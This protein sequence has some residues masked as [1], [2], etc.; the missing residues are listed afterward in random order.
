MLVRNLTVAITSILLMIGGFGPAGSPDAASADAAAEAGR[1]HHRSTADSA[2]R[3]AISHRD[4]RSKSYYG[5]AA[6]MSAAGGFGFRL[7]ISTTARA[8]APTRTMMGAAARRQGIRPV[9][10][11]PVRGYTRRYVAFTARNARRNLSMRTGYT[12]IESDAHHIMP[13]KHVRFSPGG[14]ST[15][16][17][18]S[19]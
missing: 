17:T 11:G 2:N 8:T 7:I 10:I 5:G 1:A 19:T 15:S 3:Q 18:Q 9:R 13:K 16:M 14:A 12:R 6:S 4:P